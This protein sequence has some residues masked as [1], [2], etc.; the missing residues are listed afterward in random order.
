MGTHIL[1]EL[2]QVVLDRQREKQAHKFV[3]KRKLYIKDSDRSEARMNVMYSR[4]IFLQDLDDFIH[5]V[6]HYDT[7]GKR[8]EPPAFTILHR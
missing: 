3:F 6:Y 5:D 7:I 4:L 1:N 8:L 2:G